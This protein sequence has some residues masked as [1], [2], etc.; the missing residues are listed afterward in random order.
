MHEQGDG[1]EST[2]IA[3]W[4][5]NAR[6]LLQRYLDKSS[7][8][9]LYRW[10][11]LA[12]V[13]LVYIL[14]VWYLRGFYVVT[15]GIAIFDL[16]LLLGF[17]T[18]QSNPESEPQLPTN[19]KEFRPFVRRLPEFKFWWVHCSFALTMLTHTHMHTHTYT[20]THPHTCTHT[21]TNTHTHAR[22]GGPCKPCRV[23]T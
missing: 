14:R 21:Y 19:E 22:A 11:G 12:A 8:H 9:P 15:Y 18:P 13:A 5:A 10:L 23:S 6:Q 7:P 16:N 20:P 1:Q 3:V 4:Q 17:L 2:K